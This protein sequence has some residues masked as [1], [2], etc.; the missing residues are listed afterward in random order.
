VFDGPASVQGETF[1]DHADHVRFAVAYPGSLPSDFVP[2]ADETVLS[3]GDDRY[4]QAATWREFSLAARA[5]SAFPLGFPTRVISRNMLDYNYRLVAIPGEK[6]GPG[7]YRA[8]TPDWEQFMVD[9]VLPSTSVFPAVDGGATDNEP[10]GLART[11]L[12]GIDS[13]NPRDADAANRCVLLIDPF[14]GEAGLGVPPGGIVSVALGTLSALTQQTRYDTAD[15]LLA[16]DPNVFSRFLVSADRGGIIGSKALASGGLGAFIGFACPDFA[17]HDYMLGRANCQRM[18]QGRFGVGTA[19]PVV[20]AWYDRVV[21][22][23]GGESEHV[24][25]LNGKKLVRLI[26]LFEK[27]TVTETTEPWPVGRLDPSSF[28]DGIEA[29]WKAL[30]AAELPGAWWRPFAGWVGGELTE[31]KVADFVVG[32]MQDA[33]KDWGLLAPRS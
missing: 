24:F 9:G 12:C 10:I 21:G 30:L 2:R 19:N 26:P 4:P 28:R 22:P 11:A 20:Q 6:G 17:R 27:V 18:L 15:L 25:D 5:T 14:S 33:L 1:V 29:R 32:K 16:A 23:G 3:F 8:L 7:Q 13:R 31:G